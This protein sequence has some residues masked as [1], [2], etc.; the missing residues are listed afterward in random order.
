VRQGDDV[1]VKVTGANF[2]PN[3]TVIFD[4]SP[5]ETRWLSDKQLSAHLTGRHTFNGGTYLIGVSTP[6]P[7]GGVAE[8]LNFVV[9]YK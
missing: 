2:S 7:G 3:S 8:G 9:V 6:K 5:V 4:G 1:W